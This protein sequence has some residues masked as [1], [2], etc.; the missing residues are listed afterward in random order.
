MTIRR[1]AFAALGSLII[2]LLGCSSNDSG[3][4]CT[5]R[6]AECLAS[7]MICVSSNGA[8]T[9]QACPTG[10]YAATADGCVAIP[11]NAIDHTFQ[12]FSVDPGQEITGTCQSWTV[13]NDTELWVNAV[14]MENDGAF[15]H[16]NWLFVPDTDYVGPDGTWTC[17]DR[18]LTPGGTGGYDELQAAVAGG[19]LFAQSTQAT[20]QVQKFP[21]GVAVRLPPHVRILGGTH[22]LNT[23]TKPLTTSLT[24]H[25]Y[26]I[27]RA[28]VHV[29][30]APFRLSY[31]DLHIQPHAISN[32]TGECDVSAALPTGTPGD[33]DMDLYYVM[34]HYHALGHSFQLQRFGGTNDGEV[35]Y[36]LGQ[37]DREAHSKTYDPPVAMRGSKGFRFTCG[38]QNPYSV[39]V[40]WGVGDIATD[41]TAGE[42][43]VM[44]GFQRSNYAF[45]GHVLAPA[46]PTT[47]TLVSQANGVYNYAYTCGVLPI[48]YTAKQG[49]L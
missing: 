38:F 27:D 41:P 26:T 8:E 23:S 45:D 14:E 32:F 25:L 35:L 4:P 5:Q 24:M 44:L 19:V 21:E 3:A 33:L 48:D 39:E 34:P 16:S 31:M 42:M 2:L 12:A 18:P 10:Q 20:K 49:G 28:D 37:F 40:R 22:I 29:P 7:Q 43:C 17:S 36:D 30:L 46:D 15:H 13:N 47:N 1:H 6:G 9:C 11:G